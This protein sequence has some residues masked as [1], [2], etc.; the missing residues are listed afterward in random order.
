MTRD[1]FR[2]LA[3]EFLQKE[4]ELLDT[5]RG[6]VAG[7]DDCLSNFRQV[8]E[9]LGLRRPEDVILVQLSKHLQGIVHAIQ[10]QTYTWD[11]LDVR[12]GEGLKQRF[13]DARNYLLLLAAA[14]E[15]T[16][17]SKG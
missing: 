13:A 1:E 9:F 15:E 2:R 6:E 14:I 11:W 16:V 10:T 7:D 3:A 5:K 4:E 12:G 17:S 8:Q